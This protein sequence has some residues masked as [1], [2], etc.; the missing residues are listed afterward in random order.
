MSRFFSPH[1]MAVATLIGTIIGAGVLGIPYVIAKSGFWL[2]SLEILVIGVAMLFLNLFLGEVVLRTEGKHQLVGYME[3]YLGRWGKRLMMLSM[4]FG[5]YGALVAYIVGG[6]E[7]L[8]TIFGGPAILYSLLFFALAAFIVYRGIK[9]VGKTELLVIFSMLLVVLVIGIFSFKNIDPGHFSGW[10]FKNIFVP[11]G[12]ILF[13]FLGTMAIPEL[14]EVLERDKKKM[15]KAIII[16]S[17][18][19][20]FLY[21]IFAAIVIGLVGLENFEVLAPNERI[22]TVALS[23]YT[24]KFLGIL[25]NVFAVFAMGTSF[26]TLGLAMVGMYNYDYGIR[27]RLSWILA[28]GVPLLIAASGLATFVAILNVTGIIAGGLAGTLVVLAFWKA[29]R[30]GERLPEY[31]FRGGKIIGFI[32]IAMFVFGIGQYIFSLV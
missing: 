21:A 19:P 22:A 26:L 5:I 10:D 24:G 8:K 30:K 25:A 14:R 29:K 13:A 6:G 17:L 15:K 12:V 23:L 3:K 11:Y 4:T 1:W 31:I 16:G 9:A 28:M 7:V 20:I 32:L 18:I 2:G 27:K